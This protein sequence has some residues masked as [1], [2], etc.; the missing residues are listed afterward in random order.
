MLYDDA[1][2]SATGTVIFKNSMRVS[3]NNDYFFRASSTNNPN[4]IWLRLAS[5]IGLDNQICIGYVDG[6]TSQNDGGF[7][8]AK[9]TGAV[10]NS[11]AFYSVIPVN[12]NK[13]VIQGKAPSD[14]NLVEII[15]LGFLTNI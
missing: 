3:D 11:L 5:D 2:A 10:M 6:A 13:F 9:K 1:V 8:D 12:N 14:L 15:P 4:K 7:Y